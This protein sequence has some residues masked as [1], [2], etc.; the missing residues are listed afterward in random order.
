MQPYAKTW[1]LYISKDTTQN[2]FIKHYS[3]TSQITKIVFFSHKKTI[4]PHFFT[5]SNA[6]LQ[7]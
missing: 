5:L 7:Q 4:P 1:K 2:I 6:E 3:Q